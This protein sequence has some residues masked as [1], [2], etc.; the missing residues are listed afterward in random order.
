MDSHSEY[1]DR[2]EA[3]PH[4]FSGGSGT[5][6]ETESLAICRLGLWRCLWRCLV[7]R[8]LGGV[9]H[10]VHLLGI[11]ALRLL[12][13]DITGLVDGA[14]D[15]TLVLRHQVF[16]LVQKSHGATLPPLPQPSGLSEHPSLD[17]PDRLDR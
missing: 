11:L 17:P 7:D 5:S 15:R 3:H 1:R 13:D 16:Q 14:V 12:V 4:A 6:T 2:S 8:L 9:L 10:L